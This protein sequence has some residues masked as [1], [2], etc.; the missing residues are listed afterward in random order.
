MSLDDPFALPADQTQIK[1][2]PGGRRPSKPPPTYT[3]T[4]TL[5]PEQ[6][7]SLAMSGR[8]PLLA[9]ANPLFA[10]AAQLRSTPSHRDPDSLR[11]SLARSI[12][13]FESAARAAGVRGEVVIAARYCL[14]TLLDETIASTPWG[15]TAR[16]N[17]RS[18]LVAFHNEG[19]GGEKF[20]ALLKRV[21]QDP[22]GNIDLLELMYLCLAYGFQ[23]RYRV[24][25][26]GR[27]QIEELRERLN[28]TIHNTRGDHERELSAHWKGVVDQRNPMI[29][30]ATLWVVAAIAALL[31]FF[32]YVGF[33]WSVN[34]ASD[35]VLA[36]LQSIPG[37]QAP[38]PVKHE[39]P[40][41]STPRLSVLL[42]PEI[43]SGLVAV[44]QREDGEVVTI[45][46][47]DLF[48]SG[49]AALR[50]ASLPILNRIAQALDQVPG[51]V[52]VSGHTDNQRI[53]S[54]RF[55]SNWH[56]SKER[57]A[58]VVA[59]LAGN[60]QAPQRLRAEGRADSQPIAANDSADNRAKNRRVEIVV[61]PGAVIGPAPTPRN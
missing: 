29:R 42:A 6:S 20:F 54:A 49:S 25:D 7:G 55:P 16:W 27:T 2:A 40:P 35:P 44:T 31:L 43:A 11:D 32:I 18:L 12:R 39:P 33:N 3:G 15:E 14:C 37:T 61:G 28:R 47:G 34:R 45:R 58:A 22:G 5:P 13:E 9:A 52:L 59:L 36:L 41:P 26:G 23:G 38:P 19:W 4:A 60:M 46:G 48:D 57:A 50:A 51:A 8:T 53:L 24:I 17:D 56:L 21:H 1:P 10:M 30:W